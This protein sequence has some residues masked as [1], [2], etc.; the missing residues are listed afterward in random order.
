MSLTLQFIP[1]PEIGPLSVDKKIK[2]ILRSVKQNKILLI[3]G[4]LLPAEESELIRYTM[5]SIDRKFKGIEIC[6]ITDDHKQLSLSE[7]LKNQLANF[8]LGKKNG[9]TI[10]GPANIVKEIKKDPSKIELLTF[11]KKKRR[12]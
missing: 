11:D 9:M 2:K 7:K 6:S 3:E 10:I 12:R 1:H 4:A 5:E 8:I